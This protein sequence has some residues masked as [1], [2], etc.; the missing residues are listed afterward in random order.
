ML[1]NLGKVFIGAFGLFLSPFIILAII[2]VFYIGYQ[3]I[4]GSSFEV[5]Y[6]LFIHAIIQLKPYFSYL[7][8]IPMAAIGLTFG[9]KKLKTKKTM[10][11]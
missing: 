5:G 8:F 9:I 3:M 7:T 10:D 1:K 4:G 11:D 2:G 6:Q